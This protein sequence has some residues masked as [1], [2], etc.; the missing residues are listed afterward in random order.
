MPHIII[1]DKW[2]NDVE[3]CHD[4]SEE[5]EV[6]VATTCDPAIQAAGEALQQQA[7]TLFDAIDAQFGSQ[8]AELLDAQ[9]TFIG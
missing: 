2:K 8:L 4:R 1:L 6:M 5:I 7:E 9:K 3:L